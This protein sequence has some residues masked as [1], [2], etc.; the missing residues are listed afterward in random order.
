MGKSGISFPESGGAMSSFASTSSNSHLRLEL[1]ESLV[2]FLKPHS[3]L[4]F[5]LS[6]VILQVP[7]GTAQFRNLHQQWHF[8]RRFHVRYLRFLLSSQRR[9]HISP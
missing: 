4:G 5:D 9:F 8:F 6:D 1:L 2:N 3:L 7:N